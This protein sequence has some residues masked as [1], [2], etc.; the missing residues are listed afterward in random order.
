MIFTKEHFLFHGG[1]GGSIEASALLIEIT[2]DKINS[3]TLKEVD[4]ELLV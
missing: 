3:H 2:R 1:G 4:D